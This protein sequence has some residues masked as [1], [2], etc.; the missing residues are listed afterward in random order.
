MTG[1]AMTGGK[2]PGPGAVR[3]G[4]AGGIVAL[5]LG[6]LCAMLGL[7]GIVGGVATAVVF[8][9]QGPDGYLSSPTREFSTTSYALT[10][11]PAQIG[12][13]KLPF[14]LGSIRL[15]A[16]SAPP[17]GR[18]F[19]GIG[20]KADVD[21]YLNGVRRTEITGVE[22][23]PFRV[24]YRDMPGTVSATPPGSQSFW[25]VSSSGLG[26]QQVTMD[27]RSGDWVAVI[28]NADAGPGVTVNLQAAIHTPLFGAITPVLWIGGIVLLI[29]GAAL[30]AVGATILGRRTQPPTHE[31][32]GQAATD[33]AAARSYPARLSGELD[34]QLSRGLWLVKWL[35]AVPHFFIL[36]FLWFAVL[37]TTIIAGFAVLFTGRYPRPLFDFA[38]GVL[39]WTWRVTFYAYSALATDT[40]PPFTLAATDYPADFHVD[41]PQRLSRGLVLLKWWLLAIPHLVIVGIFTG[42][43]WIPWGGSDEWS[44]NYGRA[45]GF[46]LLGLLVLVAAVMLLFT[47]RYQRALFDLIMGINRWVYRVGAYVLLL[48]DEYPPFRLDQGPWE[49]SEADA[50]TGFPAPPPIDYPD[51]PV[52]QTP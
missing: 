11:P 35:L 42:T 7:G 44:S 41:Y 15:S 2:T 3:R 37:I 6:V 29:I 30:I 40:Y 24:Q 52:G 16:A 17:G 26:T 5:V 38:V 22:S 48:R 32:A 39:R 19:I 20:P 33:A 36:F 14:N 45:A 18:V 47:G 21:N 34:Q 46:S 43:M 50:A 51:P 13:D 28:M 4:G 25:A 8:S 49:P 10:S 27:L 31:G 9:Q 23:S 12:T 1:T